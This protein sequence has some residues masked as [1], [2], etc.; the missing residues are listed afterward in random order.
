MLLIWLLVLRRL[1]YL[2]QH[3]DPLIGDWIC[4]DAEVVGLISFGNVV[5]SLPVCCVFH[6]EVRCFES[7][8]LYALCVLHNAAFIL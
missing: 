8:H 3:Q 7:H 1:S 6:V 2:V 4:F 5:K